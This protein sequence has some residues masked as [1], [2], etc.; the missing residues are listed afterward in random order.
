MAFSSNGETE[1][2]ANTSRE[3]RRRRG[4]RRFAQSR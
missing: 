2:P 4:S 3:R 1:N